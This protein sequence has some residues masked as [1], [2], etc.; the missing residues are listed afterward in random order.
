MFITSVIVTLECYIFNLTFD[1]LDNVALRVIFTV[2]FHFASE[3]SVVN[4]GSQTA[5]HSWPNMDTHAQGHLTRLYVNK[6]RL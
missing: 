1:L 4:F 3:Y 6:M 2:S 5:K